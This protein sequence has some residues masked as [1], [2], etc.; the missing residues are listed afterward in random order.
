VPVL[1][2]AYRVLY[3]K[4]E[5]FSVAKAFRIA[6]FV[7]QSQSPLVSV[8]RSQ[9]Y[10]LPIRREWSSLYINGFILITSMLES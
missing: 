10:K 8:K 3:S 1:L 5:E 2:E 6:C 4:V 7:C 9:A